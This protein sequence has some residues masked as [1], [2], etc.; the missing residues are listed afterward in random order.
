MGVSPPGPGWL[1]NSVAVISARGKGSSGGKALP[2]P[3]ER[4]DPEVGPLGM[5]EKSFPLAVT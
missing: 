2:I 5:W 1:L 4:Q 3:W